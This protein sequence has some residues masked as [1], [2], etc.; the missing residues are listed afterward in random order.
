MIRK[1]AAG[2]IAWVLLAGLGSS[3]SA[4]DVAIPENP[5]R[6][7]YYGDLHLHTSYSFDAYVLGGTKVDPDTAYRFAKGETVEYLGTPIRRREP[8]DFVA[9]TDHAEHLGELIELEDPSSAVSRSEVGRKL[10]A[11]FDRAGADKAKRLEAAIDFA[12]SGEAV[13]P[14][15][16]RASASAWARE[17]EFANRHYRPGR[18]TTFVA[19][20]FGGGGPEGENLHRNVI[21]RG[22]SAPKPFS[23]YDSKDPEDLWRYLEKIRQE[24]YE[25]LAI[26]HN[27]N[28]SNGMMYAWTTLSGRPIDRAYAELRRANEPLSEI[29]QV[30]GASETHPTLS[31]SDEFANFE[32]MDT[33]LTVD[34]PSQPPGSYLRDALSRGLVLQR[35]IGINPYKDGFGGGSD[36]HGGLSVSAQ[37]DYA[38][39]FFRANLGAG[40]A[41]REE[42]AEALGLTEQAGFRGGLPPL[43]TTSGGLAGV[44]AESNTREA[45]YAA[46][47]RR[48]TFAT[49]G[50]R[51]EFRFFG[52]WS[53]ERDLLE[54][55]DWL[56]RAYAV[57][58]PMGGDLPAKPAGSGAPRFA[59]WAVKDPEGANLDRLQIVKVWEEDGAQREKVFDVMG[60]GSR[61][62]DPK[63]GKL[64]AVG[65]SVD[66]ETGR[67]ENSIGAAELKAV[68]ADPEFDPQ[69]LAAYYLRVLEIPTPRWSTRLALEHGLP[70]PEGAS[71]VVQQRGWSSPIWYEPDSP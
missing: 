36:L 31:A 60:S 62:P 19:Y 47:R 15:F 18:F 1:F 5:V 53:L 13:G 2:A 50:T 61:K 42:A 54:R 56:K 22:D 30:K 32:I 40:K 71:P 33:Y 9:V 23:M 58:A 44:W 4:S 6:N 21:F 27:S 10:K 34:R 26:P 43:V 59:V 49:S 25:A 45:I 67:Y 7:A 16:T 11:E 35:S 55:G 57:A 65:S 38:G 48:E 68:W 12:F 63:T 17:I 52:G 39:N 46:L 51:L 14:A 37:A 69:R 28:A 24:G 8:L 29:S 3:A 20:E 64:P 70:L 66:L 41:T